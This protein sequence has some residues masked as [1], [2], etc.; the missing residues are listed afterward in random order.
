[1]T[2][3]DILQIIQQDSWMME[4]LETVKKLSLPDWWIGAGFVRSKV[5][6]TL[7]EY[8]T[9]TPIPDI[10][11]IYFDSDDFSTKETKLFTT[12]EEKKYEKLLKKQHPHL[13]WSVTNQAR[14]HHFHYD[15]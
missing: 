14:M 9:R 6:D 4:I 3:E 13:N 8:K 10:D 12:K 1:M 2:E 11:V 5:W 15:K 7:H